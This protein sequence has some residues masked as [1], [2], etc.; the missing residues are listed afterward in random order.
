MLTQLATIVFLPLTDQV[1][2]LFEMLGTSLA[3]HLAGSY[4][5]GFLISPV[6]I[7]AETLLVLLLALAVKWLLMPFGLQLGD[8]PLWG[9]VHLRW[10]MARVPTSAAHLL[11]SELFAGT[12]V[13][14]LVL[15]LFGARIGARLVTHE[16]LVLTEADVIEIGDDCT[17]ERAACMRG[18]NIEHNRFRVMR[19]SLGAGSV[20]GHHAM[21]SAGST[22]PD[23]S[24]LVPLTSPLMKGAVVPNVATCNGLSTSPGQAWLRLGVGLPLILCVHAV[25]YVVIFAIGAALSN[26]FGMGEFTYDN[27][28]SLSIYASPGGLANLIIL[29]WLYSVVYPEIYFLVVCFVKAL[30]LGYAKD[31]SR[32]DG[33]A[34]QLRL[35]ILERLLLGHSLESAMSPWVGTEVLSLKYRML[36]ARIGSRVQIDFFKMVEHELISVEDNVVFASHVIVE[37]LDSDGRRAAVHVEA[38]ANVLDNSV[39]MPGARIQEDCIL[40][41][42][43]LVPAF[44]A[45]PA[46]AVV[47]GVENGKFVYLKDN[48]KKAPTELEQLARE[49]HQSCLHWSAFNMF[50]ITCA[51]TVSCLPE[52]LMIS[53]FSAGLQVGW[54]RPRTLTTPPRAHIY[55]AQPFSSHMSRRVRRW[56]TWARPAG[57][58]GMRHNLQSSSSPS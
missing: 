4:F 26:S 48:K 36:G 32:P 45:V 15:R 53:A 1:V 49:R 5:I 56:F 35:W 12:P 55:L 41:S 18:V 11:L 54:M 38:R 47:T 44:T 39:L 7:L 31:G 46:G 33:H 9:S 24:Y 6:I 22:L 8:H 58:C 17:F 50:S 13:Y 43:S 57:S 29:T 37:S 19:T 52:V 28:F 16:D 10:W 42:H 40:G 23:R 21:L 14:T 51:A 27:A 25:P 20:V 2:Y 34:A 3:F 30:L